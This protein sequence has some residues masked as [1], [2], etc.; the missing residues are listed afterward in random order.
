MPWIG[1]RDFSRWV[2]ER[3]D[4][5]V[6]IAKLEAKLSAEENRRER[7]ELEL[8]RLRQDFNELTRL[9]AG[10]IPPKLAPEFDKDIFREDKNLPEIF[11]TPDPDEVGLSVDLAAELMAKTD[12]DQRAEGRDE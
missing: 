4:A 2:E 12:G 11:L 7:A 9:T 3:T 5:K 1:N 6:E 10:R 8:E